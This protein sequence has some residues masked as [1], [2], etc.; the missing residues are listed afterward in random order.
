MPE[1]IK[2]FLAA[3]V[4]MLIFIAAANMLFSIL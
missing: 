3:I 2:G 4:L 1:L